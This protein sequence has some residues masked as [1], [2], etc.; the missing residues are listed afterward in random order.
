MTCPVNLLR[1]APLSISPPSGPTLWP[2]SPTFVNGEEEA[3]SLPSDV[4]KMFT[5]LTEEEFRLDV[6]STELRKKMGEGAR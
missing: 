6:S 5:L 2:F 1:G 4:R 3:A